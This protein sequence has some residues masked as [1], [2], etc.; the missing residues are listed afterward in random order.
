MIDDSINYLGKVLNIDD[1]K[2][3]F[4]FGFN[5]E[6][7]R[8]FRQIEQLDIELINNKIKNN[9]I[10]SLLGTKYIVKYIYENLKERNTTE[11]SLLYTLFKKEFFAAVYLLCIK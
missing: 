9:K 8:K 11:L 5:I 2:I 7:K 10:S 3:Y 4:I 6:I 1:T